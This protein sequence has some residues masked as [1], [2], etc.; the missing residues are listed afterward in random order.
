MSEPGATPGMA[1]IAGRWAAQ[2]TGDNGVP[3]PAAELER[4]LLAVAEEARAAAVAAK[5]AAELRLAT[6]YSA[7]PFGVALVDQDGRVLDVNPAFTKLLGHTIDDLAGT[8]IGTLGATPKDTT[9][10]HTGFAE[11]RATGTTRQ[12]EQLDLEHALDGPLRTYV[13]IAGL[14]GN[15]GEALHPI[16]I[17]ED[18]SEL[19]LLRDALRRQNVQDPL[20]GLP[21]KSSFVNKLETSLAQPDD[22]QIALVY[23]DVDGF[24]VINDGLG[25]GAGDQVL[26]HVAGRLADVFAPSGAFVARLSGDGF[27]V[28]MRGDLTSADVVDLV[29]ETM[30]ELAEPCYVDGKGI[31][32]SVSV[33]IVVQAANGGTTQEDLHRAAEITLHR[34]KESGRAQWMLFE[35]GLDTRDRRRYG[36]G[37]VIG[38]AL[39]NGEFELEYQPTVKLDGS[40]EIAVVNA[41]LRWNHPEHGMLSGEEFYPL[42]DTTGMTLGLGRW[43]LTK[44]MSDAARWQAEFPSAPDLCVRLPTRLAIDPNLV[45]IVRDELKRTGLP[46]KKLRICTDSA[47]LVDPRGEVLETITVL[48]ELDVKIALA[49]AGGADLELVNTHKLPVGFVILSGPHVEALAGEGEQAEGARK[50]LGALLERAGELG[51]TRIGAEGVLTAEHAD[52]LR[53]LGIVA[54]RGDLFGNAAGGSGITELIRS[55]RAT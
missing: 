44:A 12:R 51:I 53:E 10:L 11:L 8:D 37:A 14:P 15:S 23:F 5:D 31:G 36:I 49:V 33:G 1:A 48:A 16:L 54:G 32:V 38:G 21:N 43:L 25:P 28:L 6:L 26:R 9:A 30:T 18:V 46:P 3:V 50:H 2:L 52:R 39:E 42:A 7:S 19:S 47:A 41:G 45:G 24:K 13:T 40:N 17:V 27:A 22:D 55:S 20:T 35:A 34:A 29:E 4:A